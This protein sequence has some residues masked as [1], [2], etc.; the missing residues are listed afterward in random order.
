MV[1]L[2]RTP[3]RAEWD[4]MKNGAIGAEFF[5]SFGKDCR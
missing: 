4:A 3:L 5:D 1:Y 2:I